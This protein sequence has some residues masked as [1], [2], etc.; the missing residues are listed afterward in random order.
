MYL[1]VDQRSSLESVLQESEHALHDVVIYSSIPYESI[2]EAVG[3][4]AD[5]FPIMYLR[6]LGGLDDRSYT[7]RGLLGTTRPKFPLIFCHGEA[8]TGVD[9]TPAVSRRPWSGVS[10]NTTAHLSALP[11]R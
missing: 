10:A 1:S 5:V 4:Q 9:T 8:E 3:L 7:L 2:L 6:K 11:P